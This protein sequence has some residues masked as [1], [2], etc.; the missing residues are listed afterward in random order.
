MKG[1]ATAA[2]V[3]ALLLPALAASAAAQVNFAAP[4]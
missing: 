1:L 4:A 3:A 2:A